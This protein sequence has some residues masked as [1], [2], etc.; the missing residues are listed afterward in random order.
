VLLCGASEGPGLQAYDGQRWSPLA[1]AAA[2][3]VESPALAFHAD[4]GQMVA[5]GGHARTGAARDTWMLEGDVWT[6]HDGDGPP[7]LETP[8]MVYDAA[9]RQLVLVGITTRAYFS[10]DPEVMETWLFRSGA[11]SRASSP[12]APSRRLHFGLAYDPARQSTVL[13]GGQAPGHLLSD[14]WE[15]DGARWFCRHL[16]RPR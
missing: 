15:F 1:V 14:T 6:R 3:A 8:H 9:R 13:F 7:A 4:L 11:W 2:P 5:F 10:K 16:G 12:V